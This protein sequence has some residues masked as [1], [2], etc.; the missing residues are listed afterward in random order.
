[1]RDARPA[2][3]ARAVARHPD[4]FA[5]ECGAPEDSV[6]EHL[7]VVHGAVV[8]VQE[9]A[10]A[11]G[12]DARDGGEPRLEHGEKRVESAP[13][14]VVR[15]FAARSLA[16]AVAA[17]RGDPGVERR[18][19]VNEIEAFAA[20]AASGRA[21]GSRRGAEGLRASRAARG[22]PRAHEDG[23][24]FAR[25]VGNRRGKRAGKV[26]ETRGRL[27][28]VERRFRGDEREQRVVELGR[29][30]AAARATPSAGRLR[31]IRRAPLRRCTRCEGE[32]DRRGACC[33]PAR[34]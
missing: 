7:G 20:R 12:D 31:G 33:R 10:A 28:R 21:R 22:F 14:V 3:S 13:G 18:V 25:R 23:P 19:D 9:Q 2:A 16:A 34:A 30:R 8:E 27:G 24:S 26:A 11:F 4:D 17:R 6:G 32:C 1:M 29:R 15:S 5:L